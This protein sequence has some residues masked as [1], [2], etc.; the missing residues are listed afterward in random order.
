MRNFFLPLCCAILFACNTSTDKQAGLI[1]PVAKK[2]SKEFTEHGNTRTDD[3]FW[4][5]NPADSNVIN[6]LKSENAYTEATMKHTDGL[7]KKLYDELVARIEQKYES[8]PTKE[9]GYWYYSRYD[10]DKQY[11]YYCRKKETTSA[12]EEIYMD[13]N[14]MAKGHQIYLVRGRAASRDNNWMAYAIDTNG[15]RRS[16][17]YFKNLVTKELSPESIPNTSGSFAWA[18]DHKTVYYTTNDHTVRSYKVMR[19][20]VGTDPKNDEEIYTEKDSTYVVYLSPSKDNRYIFI[21]ISSTTTAE[22]RYLDANNPRA[23]AV[24]IQPRQRDLLYYPSYYEGDV[25]Y[26]Y[27]N[28]DAK[29]FKLSKTAVAK[30]G[31][32]GWTDVIPASDTA[33]LENAEVLKD[34]IVA[35]QK[36]NGLTQI[37]VINRK[38]NSSYY[39]NFGENAYVANMSTATDA[40]ELDS[41]RYN[42]TSLTTPGTDYSSNLATK[43]KTQLKQQKVGGGFDASKYETQRIWARATDGKMVPVSIVYRKDGFKKDGSSPMLL[44]SYGSYGS[45]S[46]PYFNSSVISL[47]DRGFVYGIAHIRG[48]QEMGRAWYEDGKLLKKKNTF[49]D[50]VDCAQLLV[51]EKYTSA[52]KLF[53]NGVSAGGMLM[54]AITNLRP[55]L[56][57]G[58]LA[59]VPWMDVIT[60]MFNPDLPLTTTEYD[61]WGDPHKKEYYDYMLSWSPYDNVKKTAYPA[62]FAT[63]GLNDTQV[64]YY[65]PAKWVQRIRE[66]NTG[67]NPVLFKCNMG[68][69]H[70][71]ESGRFERQKL[72]ALKYA[73]ILDQLGKKE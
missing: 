25:F 70:G 58:I 71:G 64:P 48:G 17:S 39:V 67:S 73:F 62:I 12:P 2:Q 44:Y 14:E 22:A 13:V 1:A 51:N 9:N 68:A 27:N 41:I 36:I 61:E 43:Q 55:D 8:L 32:P 47:L 21:Y 29:N 4:L 57:K 69:G 23:S 66:N 30:P 50:F 19:H 3:Y 42:Y 31:I 10:E 59:E 16:V 26:I 7:Q 60:D 11:P 63:G 49:T 46:D 40:Y 34:Y 6:H 28:K 33:L 56:F 37:K 72:T 20:V 38:D 15:S 65:S 5:S 24:V 45:N 53:A 52:D 54:G 35:Q 18:N